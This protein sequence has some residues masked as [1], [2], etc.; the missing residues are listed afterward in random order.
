MTITNPP[1]RRARRPV[2]SKEDKV[3]SVRISDEVW[4]RARN[5]AAREGVTISHVL[6]SIVEGYGAGAVDLPKVSVSYSGRTPSGKKG[7][8]R[9]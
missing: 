9:S 7:G 8:G 5:R 1:L 2:G 6:L 4:A 3:R